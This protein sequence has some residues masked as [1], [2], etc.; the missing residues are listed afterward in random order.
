MRAAGVT[1]YGGPFVSFDVADPD[2]S[3]LADG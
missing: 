3:T 2:P 1:T